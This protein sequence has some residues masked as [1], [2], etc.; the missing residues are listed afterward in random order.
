MVSEVVVCHEAFSTN[1]VTLHTHYFFVVLILL[2]F[3]YLSAQLLLVGEFPLL[4]FSTL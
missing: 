4:L 3:R 2:N 1:D